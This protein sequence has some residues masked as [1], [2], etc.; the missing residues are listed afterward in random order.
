MLSLPSDLNTR[1][2][3]LFESCGQFTSDTLLQTVFAVD[4]LKPFQGLLPT[5]AG[6]KQDR[7]AQ[8]KQFLLDMRLR[9][10]S[11]LLLPFIEALRDLYPPEAALHGELNDLYQRVLA[12]IQP[13]SPP[14]LP[15][16]ISL[17]HHF[18][19]YAPRDG[20]QHA[21]RLHTA[22][23]QAGVRPWL[24]QRDTPA[25]YDPEAAR[26]DALRECASLLLVLT[27][28]SAN[29]QSDSAGEWRK[30]LQ[31]KKPIVAVRFAPGVALPLLLGQRAVLDFTGPFQQALSDLRRHLDALATPA[32]Q[33]RELEYRLADA[34]RELRQAPADPRILPDI[35]QLEADITTQR[36]VASDPEA[37][38]RVAEKRTE[39][40]LERERQPERPPAGHAQSKFINP[41]PLTAP[42]YFQDR[43]TENG[44][45]ADFLRD[46][47]RRLLTLVGRG[48]VGK[49]ALVCRLLK[50]LEA[51]H[52]PD[53]LGELRVSGIVYLSAV[54]SH[55]V[56]F[57]NLYADLLRLLP[58]D[59]A[60]PLAVL[61]QDPHKSVA[62]KLAP[63]WETF[64]EAMPLPVVVLLD[65]LEDLLDPATYAFTDAEVD[66]ALRALLEAA[67]HPV[68]VLLTTRIAPRELL[69]LHPEQQMTVPL[70]AGLPSPYAEAVL[71]AGDPTGVLGLK[72]ASDARLAPARE[73]TRGYPRALEALTAALNADRSTTLDDLL[74]GPPPANVVEV[75][76]GQAYSRL[77]SAAQ[78]VMQALAVFGRPVPPAAVDYL[79]Q[80]HLPGLDSTRVL[81]R[82]VN[83]RFVTKETGRYYMHPVDRAYA[84]QRLTLEPAID[85]LQS[86]I[87]NLQSRAADYF[88]ETRT[89]RSDWKSLADL[90]PQLA[91]IDLRYAAG[92]YDTAADVLTEI[93]FD[94]L[95]LWGHYRL[96]IDQHERL[97]GKVSDA[98]L[99]QNSVGNLGIA[100]HSIGQ[101]RK[102]ISCHEQAVALAQAAKDK[103]AEGAWLGNLGSCYAPLGETR[104]A[105]EL[106]E[107]ALVIFH[108]I[109]DR[110][111][112]GNTLGNLGNCYA[113]LGQ[114]RR[115]IELYE[116]ALA[117][118]R[119]IVDRQAEGNHIGNLGNCYA[120]L[121]QTRRAIELCEQA[122]A[123]AREIGDRRAEGNRIG[124]LGNCYAALGQTHRAIELYERAL[125]IFHEIG[126]RSGEG[127]TLENLGNCYAALG[128]SRRAIEL[129]EQALAIAREIGS[130]YVEG[131]G[132]AYL[133]RVLIDENR[134]PETIQRAQESAKIGEETNNQEVGSV[135]NYTLALAH[136]YSANLPAARAAAEQARK[137]DYPTNNHNELALLG[138]IA[139]R[140]NDLPAARE[141]FTAAFAHAE[142]LLVQTPE[143]LGALDAKALALAG[144]G[145][146]DNAR[147]TY[148]AA[149]AINSDPGIVQRAT[150]LLNQLEGVPK[151]WEE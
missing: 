49:T 27:P 137:Y 20:A 64:A 79:L 116:R 105:I 14:A 88:R 47:A 86:P 21:Q 72:D 84:L 26:E 131:C 132:L 97:Q 90:A 149:R 31:F 103:W 95:L 126:D 93:D 107:R 81:N 129:H 5:G 34:E 138:V 125:V 23:Q 108:E 101:V 134:Y 99:K 42:T 117:I 52:L 30:A 141:A 17:N 85:N 113:A 112:E 62:A 3:Q 32:G 55:R 147:V 13:A 1:I 69:L 150:R 51:G 54:G 10:Q 98:R 19:C 94:Y 66:A 145:D 100:Y 68:K 18:I 130:R 57:P 74:A 67:P 59:R 143:Y 38:A 15:P 48:G 142:G 6:N 45:I 53:D 76:V 148:Q 28:A 92:D 121:G 124:N 151:F 87:S 11:V 12:H 82:L 114:T 24:D 111:G 83:M 119:E 4:T 39:A 25:G 43:H 56:S 135:G 58:A 80:S 123:I 127:N 36:A 128:E 33:L 7:V 60:Q 77:D 78:K 133:A 115:A 61:Y 70:D 41:P 106:Y 75:L 140:Q 50:A 35:V 118:A 73:F 40:A 9:D 109:G 37:A 71:R 144:L 146:I 91:E 8:V 120:A 96:L 122:L 104:R 63:L 44:L 2:Q 89:P 46:P 65:N 136:L 29:V 102:A 110:S 139:L 16:P 22:L